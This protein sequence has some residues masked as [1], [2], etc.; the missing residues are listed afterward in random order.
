MVGSYEEF[1]RK[2][3][4]KLCVSAVEPVRVVLETDGTQVRQSASSSLIMN[5]IYRLIINLSNK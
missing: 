5:I 4:E 1:L 2:G 3:R